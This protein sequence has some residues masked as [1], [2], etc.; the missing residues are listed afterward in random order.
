[1]CYPHNHLSQ[2]SPAM[3]AGRKISTT[4]P[5]RIRPYILLHNFIK[6]HNLQSCQHHNKLSPAQAEQMVRRKG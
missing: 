2:Y 4:T 5:K 1:M 6:G 3:A